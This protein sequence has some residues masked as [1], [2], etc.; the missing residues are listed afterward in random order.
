MSIGLGAVPTGD[1]DPL[2]PETVAELEQAR[3][4]LADSATS[5]EASTDKVVHAGIL[6]KMAEIDLSLGRFDAALVG[7]RMV[8]RE[9]REAG[10]VA[11]QAEAEYGI[12]ETYRAKR[13]WRR[14]R[15]FYITA[16]QSFSA[17]GNPAASA[18]C[19]LGVAET[20]RLA[21]TECDRTEILATLE[22]ALVEFESAGDELGRAHVFYRGAELQ[23]DEDPQLADQ[24]YAEASQAY[25]ASCQ[26]APNEALL[27]IN[28]DQRPDD[29]RAVPPEIMHLVCER[30]RDSLGLREPAEGE[31]SADSGPPELEAA[32]DD[33]P[34]S[35][36]LQHALPETTEQPP[37]LQP[38]PDQAIQ[39]T[40]AA[41]P[42]ENQAPL[43][44]DDLDFD[45]VVFEVERISAQVVSNDEPVAAEP[46]AEEVRPDAN[47]RAAEPDAPVVPIETASPAE[48]A[49]E[50]SAAHR[51]PT[52]DP[53]EAHDRQATAP[54]RERR[55]Q[56]T[57]VLPPEDT[58]VPTPAVAAGAAAGWRSRIAAVGLGTVAIVA[59]VFAATSFLPGNEDGSAI[60]SQG[61][62]SAQQSSPLEA[63]RALETEGEIAAGRD[64]V[65]T[66]RIKLRRAIAAFGQLGRH[67]DEARLAM[68][69]ADF[70][71]QH[72]AP[73]HALGLY[74]K[75]IALHRG[76]GNQA[77]IESAQ[78][79]VNAIENE[80]IERGQLRRVLLDRLGELDQTNDRAGQ[81]PLLERLIALDMSNRQIH[82][83]RKAT[84]VLAQMHEDGGDIAAAT[85]TLDDLAELDWTLADLGSVRTDL[86]KALT[87]RRLANDAAG[88]VR[89]LEKLGDLEV[90]SGNWVEAQQAYLAIVERLD[91]A[92]RARLLLKL[93]DVDRMLGAEAVAVERYQLVLQ[94]CE[95][96]KKIGCQAEAHRRFAEVEAFNHRPQAAL[97][98]YRR[99]AEL[100]AEIDDH[101]GQLEVVAELY[102]LAERGGDPL[103]A[104]IQRQTAL[105]LVARLDQPRAHIA[106]LI[107]LAKAAEMSGQRQFAHDT[108]VEA[109]REYEAIG[110]THGQIRVLD[111]LQYLD[112]DDRYSQQLAALRESAATP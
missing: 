100:F 96:N 30:Q 102:L 94:A 18:M 12:A 59:L 8:E 42:D 66:A 22:K 28:L 53:A 39:T 43:D 65:P 93:G 56:P 37:P 57:K 46:P 108:Y 58:I 61:E 77:Q 74:E 111:S 49:P 4:R 64:D 50:P 112:E 69:L 29:P 88:E 89:T 73:A 80:L 107:E 92:D 40:E 106:G 45:D 16:Q 103:G 26:E 90:A 10:E 82:S 87:L 36:E 110:S 3:R 81:I 75:A 72:G 84:A 60:A 51:T 55:P 76:L 5:P 67:A 23:R 91:G 71:N 52:Q 19:W 21:D 24:F 70:E 27:E 32:A 2:P 68:V 44:L 35:D 38:A 7:Y 97:A 14:A 85:A 62:P 78:L 25:R 63:A 31:R 79:R 86:D 1:R 48:Q 15:D 95:H 6:S 20:D 34:E 101:A 83:A 17:V 47:A 11:G 98:S 105:D 54:R 104:E 109:L 9:L 41:A 13:E 99:A 33:V